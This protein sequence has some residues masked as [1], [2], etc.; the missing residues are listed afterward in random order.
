MLFP[1][2]ALAILGPFF[3]FVHLSFGSY[4]FEKLFT[5]TLRCCSLDFVLFLICIYCRYLLYLFSA[6]RPHSLLLKFFI[7]YSCLY[8]IYHHAQDVALYVIS[9]WT[10]MNDYKS[11]ETTLILFHASNVT[12]FIVKL[13]FSGFAHFVKLLVHQIPTLLLP[14]KRGLHS[15]FCFRF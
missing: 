11:Y 5:L 9:H 15:S 13:R 10:E 2:H 3:V 6:V 14:N 1:G 12:A 7:L 8:Q 4:A